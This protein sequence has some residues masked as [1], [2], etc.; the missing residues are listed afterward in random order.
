MSYRLHT[1]LALLCVLFV[2]NTAQSQTNT[3]VPFTSEHIKN[4]AKLMQALTAIAEGDKIHSLRDKG[5][6]SLAIPH[7]EIAQEINPNNDTLNIKLGRCYL[8]S[9]YKKK[10][11]A[12]F[13]KAYE[14]NPLVDREVHYLMG[15]GYHLAEEWDKAIYEYELFSRSLAGTGQEGMQKLIA[16]SKLKEECRNGKEFSSNP[17]RVWVDNMGPDVNSKYAEYSPFITADES[18]MIFT[19]RRPN[20][21]GGGVDDEDHRP[22]EDIYFAAKDS[23]RWMPAFNLGK[24]INTEDHDAT[25]GM[26][27]DGQTLFVYQGKRK[28][29]DILVTK[30]DGGVY[31]KPEPLGKNVNTNYRESSACL[32]F[33][34]KQLYFVSEKPGG[35]GGLDIYVS[36]WDDKKG[37]WAEATNLGPTLNTKYDEDAVFM[38]PDGVTMYFSSK[39]HSTMG[40]YDVF[41]SKVVDGKWTRPKNVGWPINSADDDVFFVVGG[42]GRNGYYASEKEG[43]Y[44]EKDLYRVTFLGPPK[45]PLLNNEDNLLASADLSATVS[46][47]VVEP[48]VDVRSNLA[49][50]KGVVIDKETGEPMRAKIELV[51][52]ETGEIVSTFYSD[53][54]TG[55][56][57]VSLPAGKNYGI[58]ISM[59]N[60]L[61][62]SENFVIPDSSGFREYPMDVE[63]KGVQENMTIALRNIFFDFDKSTLRSESTAEL[64]RL[65]ALLKEYKNMRIQI[66]G[67][68]DSKGTDAYNLSLSDRRAKV[69]VDYL[70]KAGI[71]AGRMESKGFGE[72]RPV[73]TNDTDEGRQQNRR[74]EFMIL[75][76]GK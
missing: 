46:E 60:H 13:Q 10:A 40:G 62:H 18:A 61:F 50:L 26:S 57:L 21:T 19:S 54:K 51:D 76:L 16:V 43:G 14:L 27:A 58:A 12:R 4:E 49:L 37:R 44:G 36:N 48:K 75:S 34:G 73:A 41:F 52:N 63:L 20:T 17:E 11:L 32:S 74:T 22:Y 33:D 56:Y 30:M 38:H 45:L 3:S 29:G 53:S 8:Y 15:R 59:D 64:N 5:I 23:G 71:K 67:H 25:A 69:V 24:P 55:K 65:I 1:L 6:W 7:Y 28:G 70:V 72:S 66:S 31:G 47:K 39:G 68:T 42:S 9:I 35:I 2:A